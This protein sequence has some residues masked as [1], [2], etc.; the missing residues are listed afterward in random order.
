[1][2]W[3]DGVVTTV[4]GYGQPI[5]DA[6]PGWVPVA[7]PTTQRLVGRYCT[8]EHLDPDTHADDL[9][10]A[11]AA[12][13]DDRDWTY[14]PYGPFPTPESYRAWATAAARSSDPRH[15]AVIDRATG[16]AVGTLS[17]M[18]QDPANGVIEVGNVVFSRSLQRTPISTEA[19]FLAMRHIFDDLGYRRYEWKCDGLNAPSRRAAERLGFTYEGTFRQAVVYKGHNRDTAWFALLDQDW[20]AV[21]DAFESWLDAA[22]FDTDGNQLHALRTQRA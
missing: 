16:R 2:A 10:A 9:Y 6:V 22:N 11:Y 12:A 5:G 8:L 17:L 4:N 21:R 1:M 3:L 7:V 13:P 19:Q 20:P 14:L 18:R 15:Y